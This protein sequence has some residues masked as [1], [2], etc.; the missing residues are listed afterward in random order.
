M[1]SFF[2]D[3]LE[4]V[5]LK[6]WAASVRTV[7]LHRGCA[8]CAW[9]HPN[10]LKTSGICYFVSNFLNF[11][12]KVECGCEFQKKLYLSFSSLSIS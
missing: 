8:R 4:L 7:C 10:V 12:F 1:L 3:I 11:I 2:H 9:A 5:V 6:S